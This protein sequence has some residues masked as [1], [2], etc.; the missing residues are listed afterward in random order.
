MRQKPF[1]VAATALALLAP[2][3]ARAGEPPAGPVQGKKWN[4][5]L[6][7]ATMKLS[8]GLSDVSTGAGLVTS[9]ALNIGLLVGLTKLK[10]P[11]PVMWGVMVPSALLGGWYSARPFE[12]L[13]ERLAKSDLGRYGAELEQAE[14]QA[15]FEQARGKLAE[16]VARAKASPS[17]L[18]S[19]EFGELKQ[20]VHSA[21]KDASR[22]VKRMKRVGASGAYD[23]GGVVEQAKQDV[24]G[25][26]FS[27][28]DASLGAP[29][30]N[31]VK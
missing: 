24:A 12:L 17:T 1:V 6:G 18:S 16:T 20:D 19:K 5:V 7:K 23:A 2:F 22:Q 26:K 30:R 25:M 29:T 31:L 13:A 11:A 14:K 28:S 8:R 27:I 21:L 15:A 4:A 9:Q 3:A 10:A